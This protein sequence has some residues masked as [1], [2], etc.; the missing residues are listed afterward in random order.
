MYLQNSTADYYDSLFNLLLHLHYISDKIIII[1][2]FN[3]PDIDWD[4]LSGFSLASNQFCDLVF[5]TGL[6][7]L[8]DQPTHKHGNTLDLLLTNLD[9]NI[10][11]LQINSDQLLPTDHFSIT[12]SLSISVITSSKSTPYFIFNYIKGGLPR[13][14]WIFT[15][16]W[17]FIMLFKPW[18]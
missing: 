15:P 18:H 17:F 16:L 11:H 5:Q 6:S 4:L 2:D 8:I 1:G 14:V 9:N 13:S 10:S 7:Q 3:F 12:F